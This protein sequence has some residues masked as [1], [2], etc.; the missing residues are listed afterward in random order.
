MQD[1]KRIEWIDIA[2]CLAIVA[3]V[4]GHS[5]LGDSFVNQF[6]LPLFGFLSGV[7]YNEVYSKN[8]KN[9]KKFFIKKMRTVYLPFVGFQILFLLLRNPLIRMRCINDNV[10]SIK[11]FIVDFIN[12]LTMGGG[13]KL[14]QSLW[15]LII[16]FEVVIIFNMMLFILSRIYS[17]QTNYLTSVVTLIIFLVICIVVSD[18]IILVRH[19]NEALKL[20]SFYSIGFLYKKSKFY[21][22]LIPIK[23]T[24][25]TIIYIIILY[26]VTYFCSIYSS[27]WFSKKIIAA[28]ISANCGI[29]ATILLSKLFAEMKENV[30]KRMLLFIG[31][32]TMGIMAF[33]LLSFC[34]VKATYVLI[35]Q[36]NINE[37]AEFPTIQKNELIPFYI[38]SGI[39]ISIGLYN[40]TILVKT[41]IISFFNKV[42][43]SEII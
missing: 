34:F 14:G 31:K 17:K 5:G 11:G 18:K 43:Q 37:I 22:W 10:L 9:I 39:F 4:C 38:I 41:S 42:K 3:V 1:K 33:N 8:V 20:L 2:K 19:L 24:Y 26:G 25:L 23:T 29:I 32:N 28:F 27:V 21:N 13:E 36:H 12:I 6:H 35:N 30:F 16:L 15:Y 7:V 40:A